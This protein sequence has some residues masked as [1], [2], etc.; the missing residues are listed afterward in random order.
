MK[1]NNY[2]YN[3]QIDHKNNIFKIQKFNINNMKVKLMKYK[4]LNR[5]INI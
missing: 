1:I 2:N 5:K 3:Y 4:D